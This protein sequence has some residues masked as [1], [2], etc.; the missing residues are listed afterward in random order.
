MRE[1]VIGGAMNGVLA[2]ADVRA[3][4]DDASYARLIAGALA[5]ATADISV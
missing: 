5:W 2:R 3:R 1:R 4:A